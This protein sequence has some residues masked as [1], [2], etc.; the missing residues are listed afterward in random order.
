MDVKTRRRSFTWRLIKFFFVLGCALTLTAVAVASA[1]VLTTQIPNPNDL[2]NREVVESTKIYDRTGEVLLFEIYNEEKRTVVAFED[3]PHSV[4]NATIAIEDSH[5]YKHSGISI[6]SMARSFATDLSRGRFLYASGST[7][8]QQLVKNALLSPEKTLTRKL[9]EAVIA[10]KIEQVYTKDEILGMYL[11]EIPYGSNAYGVEAAAVTYFGKNAKDVTLGE[12]AYLAALPNK[13][14]Y[15]SPYGTHTDELEQ[16]K[17]AV[18]ARMEELQFIT[19]EAAE[20]A[21]KENVVFL[22]PAKQG[23]RAPHFVMH[24]I[25]VLTEEFGEEFIKKN[26]LVVRTTLDANLQR[27]AEEVVAAHAEKIE[28]DFGAGNTGLTA[29]DPRTGEI[30]AMVGSRDY[31]DREREGNFNI[32]LAKRQPGSAFKPLV[33]AAAFEKGYTPET[34]VFDVSTEFANGDSQSYR[35]QNYDNAYR[36][37]VTLREALA[38]SINVPS[39]KVL[40]LTGLTEALNMAQ[41]LGITTLKGPN[42]YGLTLVLGGGEV[43]LLELVSAYGVFANDGIRSENTAILRIEKNNGEVV[44]EHEAKSERV[45]E[46]AVARMI[47]SILSDNAARAPAFGSASAL[48]IPGKSVAVKT[49]TTND[50]RDAWII[51]YTPSL[52]AGVWAGNNDNTPMQKK[53]AGFIVAP[54]WQDFM[55]R[56]LKDKNPESFQNFDPPQTTK[57]VLTGE[58]RG[59]RTY[60]ID[61]VSKKLATA[62]TPPALIE[63][64]VLPEIHT[65]LHWVNPDD[66]QGDIPSNP[67]RNPQY[68]NWESAVQKWVEEKGLQNEGDGIMPTE[69]DSVH[70]EENKPR[71]EIQK[72]RL[73]D[74]YSPGETIPIEITIQSAYPIKQTDYFLEGAFAGSN[75]SLFKNFTI[76]L[77]EDFPESEAEIIVKAYDEVGNVGESSI[78]IRVGL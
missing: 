22:T 68:S 50:Y 24:V 38:Q 76:S 70:T 29:L 49:G 71:I 28:K 25:D 63:T 30:L 42:Q 67:Q 8:T 53:V 27:H 52:A 47:S 58:W 21:R 51:G 64:K 72:P 31:F 9:K 20:A 7:I 14:S 18:L 57:P 26:G 40:Y 73:K 4:K 74:M 59:G 12:A 43:Q 10:I 69:E 41:R 77:P 2:K 48:Q 35:P 6:L 3:I 55:Q 1:F 66:P 78:A 32:T 23:L 75:K 16:R 13:P 65:I 54:I 45:L 56:A 60:Q 33:Y 36:G 61:S 15:Y 34:V 62:S 39:V 5:F 11:N 46:P 19:P 37:P 44:W 17:N